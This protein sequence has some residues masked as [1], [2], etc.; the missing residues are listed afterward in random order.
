MP[1]P[2]LVAPASQA[3]LALKPQGT[4]SLGPVTLSWKAVPGAK[5]Y[6]VEVVGA[7]GEPIILTVQRPEATLPALA[8]GSYS[9]TVRTVSVMAAS[10][11]GHELAGGRAA[12]R[13][14]LASDWRRQLRDDVATSAARSCR[15]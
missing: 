14:A 13:L 1:P 5:G 8:Q 4:G 9:W 7:Q 12:V 6:D 3:K 10:I 2:T 15:R 11:R